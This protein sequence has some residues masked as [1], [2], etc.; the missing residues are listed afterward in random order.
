VTDFLRD[1]HERIS[2]LVLL[3]HMDWMSSYYP[4]ALAEEWCYIFRRATANARIIFRSAH[5]A[6]KYLE[7]LELGEGNRLRDRLT[8]H[9]DLAAELQRLDRVHTYA[10]FHVADLRA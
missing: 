9:L 7:H 3:D 2:K 6:P 4:E 10:G 1:T 8:F 5:A